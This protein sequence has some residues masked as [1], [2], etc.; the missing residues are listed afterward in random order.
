MRQAAFAMPVSDPR[1]VAG[2]GAT[3]EVRRHPAA[4]RLTLRVSH[5]RRAV[6]VTMPTGARLE[7]AGNFL[8]RHID[9][10]RAKLDA[11]PSAHPF[12]HE[13]LLPV[14]GQVHRIRFTGPWHMAPPAKRLDVVWTEPRPLVNDPALSAVCVSGHLEHAPRRLKDWLVVQARKDL[15]LRVAW[16][17]QSLALRPK[18]ITIR[19]QAS[20]WGS[21]SSTGL[22]SFSWR[23]VLAPPHVL[24]YVAAHEVAHLKEMNHSKRFWALVR[25]TM[26]GMDVAKAWLNANGH[27]LHCYGRDC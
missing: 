9:W 3:V 21:C 26:P 22:L 4:R 23:L 25:Q 14:R 6:I 24:D 13:G 8:A 20:R 11:V 5:T 10:V 2:L 19:D 1:S 12:A 15:S 7:E 18:R 16:H 27:A 17:A